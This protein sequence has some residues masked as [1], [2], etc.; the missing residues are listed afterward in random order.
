MPSDKEKGGAKWRR[1]FLFNG[2]W[3][4]FY[5]STPIMICA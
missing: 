5:P 2:V 1:P 3:T 4:V